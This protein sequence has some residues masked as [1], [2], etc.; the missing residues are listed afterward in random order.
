MA[1]RGEG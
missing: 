1:K